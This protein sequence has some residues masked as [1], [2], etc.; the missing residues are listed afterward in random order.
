M[1]I[2]S[3]IFLIFL[4]FNVAI[5]YGQKVRIIDKKATQF[6]IKTKS[7]TIDFVVFETK[8][9]KK[10]PIFIYLQGSTPMPLFVKFD[11]EKIDCIPTNLFDIDE[12][13]KYY[14]LVLIS[15][16]GIPVVAEQKKLNKQFFYIENP[17]EPE[18]Y[19]FPIKYLKGDYLENYVNRTS[20]V[21]KFLSKQ[22]WIDNSKIVILGHSQGA[23]VAP[24]V[25][26]KNKNVTKIGLLS[27]NPFGRIEKNIRKARKKAECGMISWDEADKIM[28]NEYEFM[29]MLYEIKDFDKKETIPLKSWRSFS[30]PYI[31]DWL[32][33]DIPIFIAY[34][35]A[36]ITS[37]LCDVVPLY[38]TRAK[39]ENLTLKRKLNLDHSFFEMKEN[40]KIDYEKNHF[41]KIVK[42]FVN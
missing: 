31:N 12:I 3:K 24:Y 39:K 41:N 33:L 26:L 17:E 36:D 7:D 30:K 19:N 23:S 37:D 8:F 22:N 14:H 38:F 34:G 9:D 16:P 21:I 32:K 4:I 25:A 2:N 40:G 5:T 29:K 28:K 10:K 35:T 13:K 20:E 18:P 11:D 42:E 6:Q 27:P 15:K 1:K